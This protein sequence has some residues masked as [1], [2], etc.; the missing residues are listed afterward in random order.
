MSGG[1]HITQEMIRVVLL[2]NRNFSYA[3]G[4]EIVLEHNNET[5]MIPSK[6]TATFMVISV[7]IV[8]QIIIYYWS[9]IVP[10]LRPYLDNS[11]ISLCFSIVTFIPVAI[12]MKFLFSWNKWAPALGLK[13]DFKIVFVIAVVS[14]TPM[15]IGNS[16]LSPNLDLRFTTFF[17]QALRPGFCEELVYRGF[18]FGLLYR[19]CGWGF[20]PASLVGSILFGLGHAYQGDDLASSM[21]AVGFTSIGALWFSWLYAE[22]KYNLWLPV[23]LHVLMNWS[24]DVFAIGGGVLLDPKSNLFRLATMALGVAFTLYL[25]IKRRE[26]I[27]TFRSLLVNRRT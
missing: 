20:I 13:N 24:V 26:K 7:A 2:N 4:L 18:L 11:M 10:R 9:D 8:N 5:T 15:F 12:A 27:V 16:L 3:Y 23:C 25:R 17:D 21:A 1:Q 19:F 14:A 22:S 6:R